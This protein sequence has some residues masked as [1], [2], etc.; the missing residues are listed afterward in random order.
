MSSPL[1]ADRV[2]NRRL[3]IVAAMAGTF[4]SA[5]DSSI[6]GPAM[7]TIIGQ[8]GGLSL[9]SW[10]FSAYLLTSTTTVPLYGR[11]SDM[12]GRKPLFVISAALFVLGSALCGLAQSMEQLVAFRAIQG[13]GAGGIVPVTFTILGDLFSVE[14]RAKMAGLFSAVWGASAVAGP[15][16][17]GLIVEV[18]DWRWIFYLN[19]PFGVVSVWL[20]W[21][22]LHEERAGERSRIDY[23]GALLLTAGITAFLFA[24]LEIGEGASLLAPR[25]GGMILVSVVLIGWFL[26]HERRF[27]SPMMPLAL[28]RSPVIA[29]VTA[30]GTLIGGVMFGISSFVPLYVQGVLGGSPIDAGLTVAPFSIGWSIASVVSG[31]IITR[32]GYRISVVAGTFSAVAGCVSL[33]LVSP[34]TGRLPAA[35]GAGLVG[36]G[37]GLSAT[38]MLISV[39]NSVGWG[40]RGVATA[41]V[42]F[43]R[44][45]GGAVGV[46]VLGTLLTAQLTSRLSGLDSSLQS[47]NA[48]LDE[49]VRAGLAPD[50]LR[51]LTTALSSSLHVVFMTMLGLAIAAAM[52]VVLFFPRGSVEEL[53][54]AEGGMGAARSRPED[55]G[56]PSV[57]PGGR[58]RP[59]SR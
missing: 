23:L 31:Q 22:S 56:E 26:L 37:M 52:I 36:I 4:L 10:V 47:A 34:D 51:F 14:E 1:T 38:A 13:L 30:A 50:V 18:I 24:L 54:A 45:I 46:A 12:Y 33:L 49:E 3:V 20:M 39:Q 41:L 44:T 35:A 27:P 42:Q 48:L 2:T 21:R 32:A 58:T 6:V 28:F 5:L 15:T 57:H 43:S 7:P 11:L 59:A 19:L 53:Q 16:L 40:Q 9:Y 8:L 25:T 29:V 17:G 55:A